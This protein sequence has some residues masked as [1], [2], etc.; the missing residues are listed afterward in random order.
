MRVA[1][2]CA[3]WAALGAAAFSTKARQRCASA[4]RFSSAGLRAV[5]AERGID[6]AVAAVPRGSGSALVA[7]V[8]AAAAEYTQSRYLDPLCGTW[9]DNPVTR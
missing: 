1:A 6:V 7:L 4:R 5:A 2:A 9:K 3:A 8:A